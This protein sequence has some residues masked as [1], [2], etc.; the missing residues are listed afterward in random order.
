MVIQALSIC[1]K[2]EHSYRQLQA[3]C[4]RSQTQQHTNYLHGLNFESSEFL[5]T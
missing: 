3:H 4:N 2:T 5:T 1:E